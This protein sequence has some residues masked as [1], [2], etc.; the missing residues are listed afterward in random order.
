M[1]PTKVMWF[2]NGMAAAFDENGNQ[3]PEFQ[4]THEVA[5]LKLH[6]AGI[7]WAEATTFGSP[8]CLFDEEFLK[9]WNINP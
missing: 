4:G 9:R 7:D 8:Q 1:T 6:E 5:F 2:G 3:V